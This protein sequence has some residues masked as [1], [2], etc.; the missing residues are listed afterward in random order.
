ML[1]QRSELISQEMEH[2]MQN[3]LGIVSDLYHNSARTAG[4]IDELTDTF[5]PRLLA[6]SSL[7]ELAARSGHKEMNVGALVE[8]V[9]QAVIGRKVTTHI[10]GIYV[11][12]TM[13]QTLTLMLNEL[14]TNAM[15]YGG[16][17]SHNGEVSIEVLTEEDLLT[18]IWTE[19]ADYEVR[20]PVKTTGFGMD[21]LTNLAAATFDGR[22]EMIWRKEGLV[23][24]CEW[25]L[26][27]VTA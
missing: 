13:A 18:L 21:V 24:R 9:M 6:L 19:H 16:L 17:A 8:V 22:P 3:L 4:S 15:K 5:L 7:N 23:F 10:D 25:P 20:A 12:G 1:L 26:D 27:K 2:R 11:N 14:T